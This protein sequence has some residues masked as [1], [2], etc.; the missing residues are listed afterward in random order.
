[1]RLPPLVRR[2]CAV[3]RRAHQ[4]MAEPNARA[5]VDQPRVL[6]GNHGGAVDSQLRRGPR[7]HSRV[8]NGLGRGDVKKPLRLRRKR[9]HAAQE[10]L[11]DAARQPPS[12]GQREAA[13]KLGLSQPSRQLQQR[14][15]VAPRL[16]HDPVANLL[17]E[18]SRHHALQQQACIGV[19]E[20]REH[21]LRQAVE[22]LHVTRVAN[23]EHHRDRLCVE[24]PRDERQ[25]RHRLR[26]QPLDVVE[27]ADERP[28][29][30]DLRQEA[31]RGQ[32]DQESLRRRPVHET[33]RP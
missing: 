32:A 19:A 15:R 14:E 30:G 10:T 12:L 17:V 26:V 22:L 33:E 3:R 29:L 1:M 20:T 18:P 4:G 6:G 28:F 11:L 9:S 31:E 25:D 5:E 23:R 7:D 24:P 13:D 16:G 2:R 8:A 21:E 27:Q